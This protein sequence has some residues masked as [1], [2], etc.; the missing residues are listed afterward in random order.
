MNMF[1]KRSMS[2]L[3]AATMLTMAAPFDSLAVFAE[4]LISTVTIGSAD[5]NG[6]KKVD[7]QDCALILEAIGSTAGTAAVTADNKALN[8]YGDEVI[9]V[10][11]LMAVR[12][13]INGS[14]ATV[15]EEAAASDRVDLNV[16][17]TTGYAGEQA[18]IA[19]SLADWEMDVAAYEVK[20][21][22]DTALT[23]EEVSCT[24]SA[25]WVQEEGALKLYG[26]Y[27]GEPAYRGTLATITVTLP[28]E[29]YGDYGVSV[30]NADFFNSSYQ[31]YAYQAVTGGVT[32][33]METKPVYLR[34][35]ELNSKSL[36]LTWSMPFDADKVTGYIISRDGE[37]IGRTEELFF[38][39]KELETGKS[40]LYSVQAYGTDYLS[41]PSRTITVTPAAPVIQSISLPDEKNA[42]GGK[43]TLVT[44]L[45]EHA[46]RAKEYA[47][48][49]VDEE[50]SRTIIS[51]G[52]DESFSELQVRWQ[53]SDLETGTYKL[54]LSLTD[55]DGAEASAETSVQ[56]DN[57]PP[58]EV[59]GFTVIPGDEQNELTWGIAAELKVTGYRIY[60]RTAT[61]NYSE[62][63]YVEGRSTLKYVDKDVQTG[64]EYFYII[65]AVDKYGLEGAFSAEVSGSAHVDQTSPEITLFLPGSGTVL[66][67]VVTLNVK[68][69]DNI[70]ISKI[71]CFLS[72][73]EGETWTELFTASGDNIS[74]R[75]DTTG[76]EEASVQIKAIAYD[77]AGNES[78]GANINIY[79]IDNKGP[80]QVGGLILKASGAT[81]ATVAWEDVADQDLRRFI[82]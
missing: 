11:D 15:P 74:Y 1:F 29:A 38:D 32:V 48:Y 72:D 36:Q 10:R 35:S 54:G 81:T 69:Q 4:D 39:D 53:L 47:L 77:Y 82:V 16:S 8:V 67:S 78:S 80:E 79:A 12:D 63:A 42:V 56:V 70:G 52:K 61:S 65:A 44:C 43:S 51:Q 28:P 59:F 46:V 30:V 3:L 22:L 45:L 17:S 50:G 14:K 33:D 41:A 20:L 18:T 5:V 2:A 71:T 66:T 68:A 49:C 37:E 57:T 7:E 24:G 6:D 73:D 76:Y 64:L 19:V 58:A 23:V 9:D 25:Q 60:R 40:Y 62:L 55:V 31:E 75:F 13:A 21:S 26:M 27:G 34:A